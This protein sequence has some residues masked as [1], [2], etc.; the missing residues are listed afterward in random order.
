MSNKR[1]TEKKTFLP[2]NLQ[3]QK[4]LCWPLR[5]S[6][7][8]I[9][10]KSNWISANN[11]PTLSYYIHLFLWFL[12]PLFH[13]STL[14]SAAHSSLLMVLAF[15]PLYSQLS[16]NQLLKTIYGFWSLL[17]LSIPNVLKESF[18]EFFEEIIYRQEKGLM[19]F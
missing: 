12:P 10:V 18:Q 7:F 11:N 3:H 6:T 1:I 5:E 4:E 16:S 8:N 17:P 9:Y 15:L 13:P 14:S 19:E 2:Q